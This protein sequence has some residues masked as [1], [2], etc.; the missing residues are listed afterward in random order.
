VLKE[1][2]DQEAGITKEGEGDQSQKKND[3][4]FFEPD[5]LKGMSK[6]KREVTMMVEKQSKKEDDYN[7]KIQ[8]EI[9]K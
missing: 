6:L 2:M 3:K 1:E 5:A 9:E 7:K 4:D 8:E